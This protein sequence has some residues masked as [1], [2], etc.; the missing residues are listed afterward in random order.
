MNGN[1]LSTPTSNAEART[2]LLDAAL[3]YARRGWPV[4]PI[5]EPLT[6]GKCSCERTDCDSPGK[7][8]RTKHGLK[9]ATTVEATI[10]TWWSTWPNA[11]IGIATGSASGLIV[12]DVDRPQ[13]LDGWRSDT[14]AASTGKGTHFYF[15]IEGE[16]PRNSASKLG[17]GL[18]VRGQGGFVVAPPSRHARGATYTWLN[19][20]QEPQRAPVWLLHPNR[21]P[22]G[23]RN[24]TLFRIA[25]G[26]RGKGRDKDAILAELLQI[27]AQRCVPPIREEEVGRIS[28]SAMR[29]EPNAQ[30]PPEATAP[31]V[32][33][34]QP[35]V[36]LATPRQTT[37]LSATP[38]EPST[39]ADLIAQAKQNPLKW[40]VCDIVLEDGVH[41]LHGD[42]ET[43]KTMLALQLHE[44]LSVG[45]RFL[46][47]SVEGRLVTGIAELETKN[48]QFAHR[49]D[50]FFHNGAPDIR[51]LPDAS[52]QKVL[53]EHTAKGRIKV[54]ADWAEA[55]GLQFVSIDSVVKLFPPG[56]DLNKPD[57][58]SEVFSQLQRLPTVWVIAHDRKPQ[59]GIA[60]KAARNAEIVGSGRFAQDPDVIHQMVRPDG[61]APYCVFHWGKMRDG[62]KQDPIPLYFDRVDYRL[63]PLHPFL[64]LLE[65]RPMLGTELVAEAEPRYGWEERRAR[66][67]LAALPGLMDAQGNRAV[68]ETLERHS[69]RY[70]LMAPAVAS[71]PLQLDALVSP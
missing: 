7:H 17:E 4:F 59:P 31:L 5:Y 40:I 48:R 68:A 27:N 64:H 24:E 13:V 51:V 21:I 60:G 32:A 45:G 14:L 35:S 46:L 20:G 67:Y 26:M 18:D 41:V 66:Q 65:R 2:R 19:R 56:C 11:N 36:Q 38:K 39:V 30:H 42:E 37:I 8:P 6:D 70:E 54:I 71:P 53:A 12:L 52:R 43:F 55:E 15:T 33:P 9:D 10:R 22:N 62:E 44:A 69:K 47:R 57:M 61:R 50:K 34:S 25:S 23:K 49:L 29:Y 3:D 63:Y 1:V 28:E 16:G 58:A